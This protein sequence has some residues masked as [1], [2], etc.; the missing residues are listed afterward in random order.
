MNDTLTLP[1]LIEEGKA[2]YKRGDFLASAQAYQ[3]AAQGYLATDDRLTAAEMSNNSSVAYLRL[4]DAAAA[5]QAVEG[6][7]EIFAEAQD[8]RRQGVA[9]GNLGAA[10]DALKRLDEAEAAYQRSADLLGQAGENDLRAHVLKSLSVIQLRKGD[11]V[12][13]VATMQSSMDAGQKAGGKG[14][15]FSKLFKRVPK[16]I[17]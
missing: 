13:A 1:E 3:A 11:Q 6:T 2:A 10:L 4:G 5:L 14:N 15:I 12:Q 17:G 9:L 8:T 16:Q 7:P